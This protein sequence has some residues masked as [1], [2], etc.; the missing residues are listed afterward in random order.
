MITK[1]QWLKF[2]QYTPNLLSIHYYYLKDIVSI[3]AIF[4]CWYL[5]V[6]IHSSLSLIREF[7]GICWGVGC[8]CIASFIVWALRIGDCFRGCSFLLII[9]LFI[10]QLRE[11][12]CRNRF[13]LL[14]IVG[15]RHATLVRDQIWES[16]QLLYAINLHFF[17]KKGQF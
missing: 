9:R 14:F 7:G 2:S 16:W 12:P 15:F 17:M 5:L 4:V 3:Q 1:K 11:Y 8:C 10:W 13:F 6:R